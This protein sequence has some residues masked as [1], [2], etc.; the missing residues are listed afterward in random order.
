MLDGS[1]TL[2]VLARAFIYLLILLPLLPV[3]CSAVSGDMH[4]RA[5]SAITAGNHCIFRYT[6]PGAS[7][8]LDRG[9]NMQHAFGCRSR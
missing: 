7:D 5:R 3:P 1:G 9:Y 2:K 8:G 4:S 6:I